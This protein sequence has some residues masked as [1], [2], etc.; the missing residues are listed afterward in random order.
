MKHCIECTDKDGNA[1]LFDYVKRET[2]YPD[3]RIVVHEKIETIPELVVSVKRAWG[4]QEIRREKYVGALDTET[5][6][7]ETI[8]EERRLNCTLTSEEAEEIFERLEQPMR[9]VYRVRIE[10]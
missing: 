8:S 5:L 6:L 1:C 9:P 7:W 3:G 2:I 10:K 4:W